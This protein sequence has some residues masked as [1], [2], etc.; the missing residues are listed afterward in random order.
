MRSR[1]R[2]IVFVTLV[3]GALLPAAA[4]SSA[5]R[6]VP[7]CQGWPAT[8][9]GTPGPEWIYGTNGDD[10]IVGLGG[11]D[12]IYGYGGMDRICGS[13]G[14]DIIYGGDGTDFL[15][16]NAGGD[17]LYG[18][19]HMDHLFGGGGNDK[20]YPGL[21]ESS[22]S[23]GQ[24]GRD[25]IYILEGNDNFVNGGPGRDWLMFNAA[26]E[27]VEINLGWAT[28]GWCF[29]S[30]CPGLSGAISGVENFT[31]TNFSDTI[32]GDDLR[33]IIWGLKGDDWLIGGAG[34][35]RILGHDGTDTLSGQL[36]DDD[37]LGGSATDYGDGGPD[38][39]LGGID[40]DV[41]FLIEFPQN[42]SI[43]YSKN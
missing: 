2:L 36:G 26:N 18:N 12:I 7:T 34:D 32:V 1:I 3:A 8:Q 9:V 29:A 30:N 5:G 38:S 4:A 11:D 19:A 13:G 28:P 37:L 33:N 17:R 39:N 23:Y 14:N 22:R 10:V 24:R 16:G 43:L 27:G 41:C 42:C 40:Q 15:Y 20:L 25:R 21:G 31:G 35:D 6:A